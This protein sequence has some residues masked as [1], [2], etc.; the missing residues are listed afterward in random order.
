MSK[1]DQFFTSGSTVDII[2]KVADTI[3]AD[4]IMT[5]NS[6]VCH[7]AV[8]EMAEVIVPVISESVLDPD[9]FCS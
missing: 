6:T 4:F 7:G 8:S 9:Y 1:F 3:C 5:D 2:E